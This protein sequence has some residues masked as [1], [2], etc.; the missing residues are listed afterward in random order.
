MDYTVSLFN[1]TT[2]ACC[3]GTMTPDNTGTFK[4]EK[5]GL[6]V[7]QT[8]AKK[9][10]EYLANK[11]IEE[12]NDGCELDLTN[13]TFFKKNKDGSIALRGKVTK[14]TKNEMEIKLS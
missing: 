8:T 2:F 11:V 12:E 13:Y 6:K 3:H 10:V 1:K 4:C 9:I 5:C 14:F 7:P